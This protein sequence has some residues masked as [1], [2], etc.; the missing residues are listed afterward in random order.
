MMMK[1]ENEE[2][3]VVV[4]VVDDVVTLDVSL[5]EEALLGEWLGEEDC[6]NVGVPGGVIVGGTDLVIVSVVVS[7]RLGERD[8]FRGGE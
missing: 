4:V 1:K 5:I 3:K 8:L 2:G 6:G 7:F